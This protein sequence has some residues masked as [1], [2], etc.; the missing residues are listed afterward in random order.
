MANIDD[1]G[2]DRCVVPSLSL[3]LYPLCS[4]LLS[5]VLTTSSLPTISLSHCHRKAPSSLSR[6]SSARHGVSVPSLLAIVRHHEPF[7]HVQCLSGSFKQ[8]S[9]STEYDRP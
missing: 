1:V 5:T 3:L 6:T 4:S 8:L 7:T 9:S 2:T